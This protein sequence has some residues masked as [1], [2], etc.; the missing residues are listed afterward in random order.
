[1]NQSHF[2]VAIPAGG[3]GT[4][5]GALITY[6]LKS[7]TKRVAIIPWIAS[8]VAIPALFGFFI[9]CPTL[10]IAG[11]NT[12]YVNKYVMLVCVW[13]GSCYYKLRE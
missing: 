4:I 12:D 9:T 7:D 10:Q 8:L 1:M 13:G 6:Y 11:I 2:F 5:V 3:I